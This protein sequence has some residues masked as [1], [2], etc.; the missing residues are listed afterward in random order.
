[1]TRMFLYF[2]DRASRHR[3]LLITNSMHFF[4]YLFNLSTCFE[5]Q[6]LIIRRSICINTSTGMI[7]LCDC[8]VCRSGGNS[9]QG[10]A[11]QTVT[12]TNHT[13]WCINTI[14]SP[15]D[16]HLMLETCREIK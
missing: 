9:F 6:V 10:P 1:M 11:Y 7:S 16:E 8:L 4:M 13:R 5:H 2:V 3:F 15:A 12:Q 14:R